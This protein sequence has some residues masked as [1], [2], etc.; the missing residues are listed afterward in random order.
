MSAFS[1]AIKVNVMQLR[2]H[3]SGVPYSHSGPLNPSAH[4][5]V[6]VNRSFERMHVP[7]FKQGSEPQ[8]SAIK[9]AKCVAKRHVQ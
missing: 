5:H 6:N 9:P 2:W 3:D 4:L 7:A 1:R 8:R